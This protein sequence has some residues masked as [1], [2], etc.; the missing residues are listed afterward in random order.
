MC[1]ERVFIGDIVLFK[2]NGVEFLKDSFIVLDGSIIIGIYDKLPKKHKEARIMDYRGKIICPIKKD[3][4]LFRDFSDIYSDLDN[5]I[6]RGVGR[7]LIESSSSVEENLE[8]MDMIEK[9]GLGAILY[10]KDYSREKMMEFIILSQNKYEIVK[11]GFT[12]SNGVDKSFAESF[13]S[14]YLE[15]N[16]INDYK[17]SNI[18]SKLIINFEKNSVFD[19]I[20]I[21][22][23]KDRK[24]SLEDFLS[25]KNLSS[26]FQMYVNGRRV[27]GL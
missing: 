11:S 14:T 24:K 4:Y 21:D 5:F 10:N 7:L 15:D 1:S 3:Y 23:G 2:K 6:K 8:I 18:P 12:N 13:G 9:S 26:F 19:A 17:T 16:T 27:M 25:E 22:Y 20:I